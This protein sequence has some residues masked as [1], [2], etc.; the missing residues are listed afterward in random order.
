MIG[1]IICKAQPNPETERKAE[2]LRSF[3]KLYGYVRYFYPGDEAAKM[4]YTKFAIYDIPRVEKAKNP[5]E[6]KSVLDSLFLPI[7]PGLSVYHDNSPILFK[8]DLLKPKDIQNLE[9]I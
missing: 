7:A 5:T 9:T 6:L 8:E 4:D 1:F 2:N 3:A